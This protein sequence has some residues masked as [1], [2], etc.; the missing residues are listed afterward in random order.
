M[1]QPPYFCKLVD[2]N[3]GKRFF[4]S[5]DKHFNQLKILL[6]IFD[7]KTLNISYSCTHNFF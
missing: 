2:I 5:I 7:R 3:I 4:K 1:L 6:K